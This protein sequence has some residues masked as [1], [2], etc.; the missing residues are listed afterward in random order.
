MVE[1]MPAGPA[2]VSFRSSEKRFPVAA[3]SAADSSRYL[4]GTSSGPGRPGGRRGG[5]Q[6]RARPRGRRRTAPAL[7]VLGEVAG[8]GEVAGE[9]SGRDGSTRLGQVRQVLLDRRVDVEAAFLAQARHH[10]RRQRHRHFV[11]AELRRARDRPMA[12]DVGEAERGRPND[13]VADGDGDRRA[14]IE[15]EDLVEHGARLLDRAGVG[16][17]GLARRGRPRG[18]ARRRSRAR[19][20]RGAGCHAIGASVGPGAVRRRSDV[21]AM[22]AAG[23]REGDAG[24][25]MASGKAQRDL[26]TPA[27]RAAELELV[28]VADREAPAG[29][30]CCAGRRRPPRAPPAGGPPN[31][32]RPVVA[33]AQHEHPVLAPRRISIRPAPG[34]AATP[35]LIAFSTSGW[36]IRF[37]T[38]ASASSGG[39]SNA[40]VQPVLEARLLDLEVDLQELELLARAVSD[41]P[42]RSG[43]TGAGGPPGATIVRDGRVAVAK[44]ERQDAVQRVEEEVRVELHL[45]RLQARRASRVLSCEAR[46][47]RSRESRSTTIVQVAPTIAAVRHE[48]RREEERQ[49]RGSAAKLRARRRAESPSAAGRRAG[50]R[51]VGDGEEEP[52][53]S[54]R[55]IGPAQCSRVGRQRRASQTTERR[56]AAQ[57]YEERR[58]CASASQSPNSSRWSWNGSLK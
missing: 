42:R 9:L 14:G 35:C 2:M 57:R 16:R 20:A 28:A 5:R 52:P 25:A 36:R 33:H 32:P 48:V 7:L 49:H 18:R 44:D 6:T 22:A 38:R 41:A 17:L 55:A 10:G 30:A 26:A 51:A 34:C 3:S 11:D 56:E 12:V 29:R 37:G 58:L 8:A 54:R 13:L 23:A 19:R 53:A 1:A 31:R 24:G 39:T 47:S 43:A 4:A 21:A 45:Q 27:R 50:K 40:T 46:S 15:L